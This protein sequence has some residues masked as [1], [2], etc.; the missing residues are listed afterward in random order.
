MNDTKP[1]K[2]NTLLDAIVETSINNIQKLEYLDELITTTI[3]LLT[4]P[5]EDGKNKLKDDEPA[6]QLYKIRVLGLAESDKINM[7]VDKMQNLKELL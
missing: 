6:G 3:Y 2:D 7:L 1:I 4:G 5:L